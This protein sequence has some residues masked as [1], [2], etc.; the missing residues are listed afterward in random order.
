MME[1]MLGA[2]ASWMGSTAL[3]QFVHNHVTVW[4]TLE[5]FHFVGLVMVVGAAGALDLRLLGFAR[6]IPVRAVNE[7]IPWAYV[8]LG[9]NIVTGLLFVLA[10]PTR[11]LY[12]PAF[13]FKLLFLVVAGVNVL[14]FTFVVG[15]EALKVGPGE[16]APLSAKVIGGTSLVSWFA[17]MYFGRMLPYLGDR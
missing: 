12:N 10:T 5:I 14:A 2:L 4:P 3:S 8:G 7:L 1:A 17:V 11:F 15:R 13:G 6:Q 9:I 16:D